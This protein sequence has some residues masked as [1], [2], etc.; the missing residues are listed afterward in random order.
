MASRVLLL[1]EVI[2]KSPVLVITPELTKL[3]PFQLEILGNV[4]FPSTSNVPPSRLNST[5]EAM[6]VAPANSRS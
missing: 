3:P 6:A 4:Q 5:V 1:L 2:D